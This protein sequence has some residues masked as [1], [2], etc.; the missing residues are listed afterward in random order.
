MTLKA[1]KKL[2]KLSCKVSAPE[3]YPNGWYYV[4]YKGGNLMWAKGIELYQAG[5]EGCSHEDS[6]FGL[7]AQEAIINFLTKQEDSAKV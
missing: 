7:T 1:A 6:G 4:I 3:N 2:V 5:Y